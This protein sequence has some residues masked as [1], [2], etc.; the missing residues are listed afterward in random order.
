MRILKKYIRLLLLLLLA[1]LALPSAACSQPRQNGM[2]VILLTD[3]GT[4]SYWVPE[5]KGI[6]YNSNPNVIMIDATHDIPSFDITSAAFILLITAR[7]FPSNVVIV[8][9]VQPGV[10]TGQRYMA[11]TTGKDQV[12]MVPD[13][14]LATLVIREM[15]IHSLYEINNSEL[16]RVP[17]NT[18]F[19]SEILGRAGG[20]VASGLKPE[21]LG[22]A[23]AT[24]EMF[25]MHEPAIS[26]GGLT[27][28]A[29][30]VDH[31]GNCNTNIPA[32]L[33]KN[34]GFK[35]GD[36]LTVLTPSGEVTAKFGTTY[37]DVPT[38]KAVAFIDELNT[39][40]LSI[41]MGSFSKTY[42]TRAGSKI[43]VRKAAE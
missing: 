14:G 28:M 34:T 6:V 12:L 16:Y 5:L 23:L 30:F 24:P 4:D 18:L 26:A 31:F 8:A 36:N 42:E 41:N 10:P 22:P 9:I 37:A 2:P 20:L 27:G 21:K 13:N 15:G 33:I 35:V 19:Y 11:L 43:E 1:C 7:E 29:V 38:G 40:K 32:Q 3:F 25:T 17:V 39:L